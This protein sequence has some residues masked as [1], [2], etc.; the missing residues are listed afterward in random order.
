MA[1]SAAAAVPAA[2]Q[3]RLNSRRFSN[4][5]GQIALGP[6]PHSYDTSRPLD[7]RMQSI[8]F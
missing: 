6:S 7:F 3:G 4:A 2:A 5:R 1:A 8:G